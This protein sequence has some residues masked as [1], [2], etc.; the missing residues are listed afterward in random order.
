[1]SEWNFPKKIICSS[2]PALSGHY[3]LN[4]NSTTPQGLPLLQFYTDTGLLSNLN[5]IIHKIKPDFGQLRTRDQLD[6]FDSL[7]SVSFEGVVH[8]ADDKMV[9]DT[10][11]Q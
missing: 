5:P 6:R 1:M 10:P 7:Q 11:Y 8:F 2:F 3:N 4:P 9:L